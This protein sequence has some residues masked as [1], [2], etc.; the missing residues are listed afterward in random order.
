MVA[1]QFDEQSCTLNG[2]F[3]P[4]PDGTYLPNLAQVLYWNPQ[5]TN[6]GPGYTWSGSTKTWSAGAGTNFLWPGQGVMAYN[7]SSAS[8]TITFARLVRVGG[9]P[10]PVAGGVPVTSGIQQ[11]VSAIVPQPGLLS[12]QLAYSP[13]QDDTA[14]IWDV[15][16]GQY[17]VYT[18][19]GSAWSPSQP[20]LSAGQAFLIFPSASQTWNRVWLPNCV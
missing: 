18:Y 11:V 13:S 2:L 17:D 6:W 20:T 8:A 19:V 5:T 12:S 3:N 4:M 14:F 16:T 15:G 1:N 9:G 7:P 10:S